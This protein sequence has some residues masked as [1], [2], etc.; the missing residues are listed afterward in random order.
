M[1]ARHG[2]CSLL[3]LL[4]GFSAIVACNGIVEDG[5]GPRAGDGGG[6]ADGDAG[7][8]CL[9]ATA[10]CQDSTECCADLSC[11]TTSLGQVCC[12]GEGAP[13]AT[14][15]GEDCCGDLECIDGSCG[16]ES[17]PEGGHAIAV[18]PVRGKHNLGYEA[19]STGDPALWT[20]GN[21][22]SNSD[23]VPGDHLGNDIWAARGTP[24]AA[25]A[26]G[27]LILTGYNDYSGNKVTIQTADGWE[28]FMCHLDHLA[29]GIANGVH[30][31]AGQIVG[32][33]GNTGTAS[34]GVIHLHISV[35]P[36]DNYDAGIDPWPLLHAVE[37][38]TCD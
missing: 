20:C 9:A 38:D 25:T 6:N 27:D 12:G 18:F 17:V 13:C 35:Y 8:Q 23:F 10:P 22:N 36:P 32:Y 11:D 34:N 31:T 3:L 2:V 37:H 33:V 4:I 1:S 21:T 19:P 5:G 14:P 29:P 26:T 28:H 30:V 24:V 15:N 16:Y 7:E